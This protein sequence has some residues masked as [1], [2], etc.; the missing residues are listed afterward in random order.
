MVSKQHGKE[1]AQEDARTG[2]VCTT[3]ASSPPVD[4]IHLTVTVRAQ[5]SSTTTTTRMRT[6]QQSAH[7][8]QH[9]TH[10]KPR[11]SK[12]YFAVT[13]GKV[14]LQCWHVNALPCAV[15]L[16]CSFHCVARVVRGSRQRALRLKRYMLTH[17]LC[18]NASDGDETET[19]ITYTRKLSEIGRVEHSAAWGRKYI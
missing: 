18:K 13:I 1:I 8:G 3:G 9:S 12:S 16:V 7:V 4:V 11:E 10:L 17:W 15:V 5:R 2:G 6:P 14:F 19:R